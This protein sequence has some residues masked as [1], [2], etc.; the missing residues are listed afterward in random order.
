MATAKQ[1][2]IRLAAE[3]VAIL[4]E[5]QSRTGLFGLSDAMRFALRHYAKTEGIEVKPKP[6]RKKR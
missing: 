4:E 5:I 3:D 6:R 2:S 1:Q